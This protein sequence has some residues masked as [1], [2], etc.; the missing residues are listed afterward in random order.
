SIDPGLTRAGASSEPWPAGQ[1]GVADDPPRAWE[2]RPRTEA[3]CFFPSSASSSGSHS[4]VTGE[5][6]HLD[7]EDL[8]EHPG[9]LSIHLLNGVRPHPTQVLHH[10]LHVHC[11]PVGKVLPHPVV[12]HAKMVRV[13]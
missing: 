7:L 1:L 3:A 4:G 12:D 9:P 6:S 5:D 13:H 8:A 2:T 10:C 11:L